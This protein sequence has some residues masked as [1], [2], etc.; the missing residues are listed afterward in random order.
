MSLIQITRKGL[1]MT[2]TP[3]TVETGAV[4]FMEN[5][6]YGGIMSATL[7]HG[8]HEEGRI[9]VS[10]AIFV[11]TPPFAFASASDDEFHPDYHEG[12]AHDTHPGYCGNMSG[13]FHGQ[14]VLWRKEGRI[15]VSSAI[16]FAHGSFCFC[17]CLLLL[18]PLP[19]RL[20][21]RLGLM[22]SLIRF[23]TPGLGMTT[24]PGTVQTGAVDSMGNAWCGGRVN[25]T[26]YAKA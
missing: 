21:L 23:T 10:S 4:D 22:I 15:C 1:R 8:L 2:T 16:F 14:C 24:T 7:F 13:G 9:C 5:V 17:L 18:L 6:C 19:L 25:A 11:L 3:G 26:L 12:S 20:R